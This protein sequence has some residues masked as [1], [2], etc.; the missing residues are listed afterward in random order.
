MKRTTVTQ[1]KFKEAMLQNPPQILS[2]CYTRH[3]NRKVEIQLP[4]DREESSISAPLK[5]H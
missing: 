1:D 3:Y 4:A 2:T 5:K